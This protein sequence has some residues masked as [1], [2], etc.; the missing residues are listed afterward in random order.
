MALADAVD[1]NA[2]VAEEV[3][4]SLKKVGGDLRY[5]WSSH[6][7]PEKHMAAFERSG[8]GTMA[9]FSSLADS[10]EDCVALLRDGFHTDA[11]ASLENRALVAR[12]YNAVTSSKKRLAKQDEHDAE[13]SI[14][15]MPKLMPK[16]DFGRMRR[17]Y[18]EGTASAQRRLLSSCSLT[19]ARMMS[20]GRPSFLKLCAS[21]I[22]TPRC[23]VPP[24]MAA[25]CCV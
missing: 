15:R 10:I 11:T 19:S 9:N 12:I 16:H 24:S 14:S 7:V 21:K 5:L 4:D 3:A 20:R 6:E 2:L 22:Q 13:S 17:A 8:F 1:V 18:E 23:S 25:G